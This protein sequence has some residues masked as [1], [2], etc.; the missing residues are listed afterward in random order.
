MILE[1]SA[2]ALIIFNA[3]TNSAPVQIHRFG[4]LNACRLAAR[5]IVEAAV[6]ASKA[7]P[8]MRCTPISTDGLDTNHRKE[9]ASK[10]NSK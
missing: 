3:T 8:V 1:W 9:I 5:A 10:R 4:D 2:Y 6:E 7:R